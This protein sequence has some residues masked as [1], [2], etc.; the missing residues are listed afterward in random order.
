MRLSL[1]YCF[2]VHLRDKIEF[3]QPSLC[4]ED[5]NLDNRMLISEAFQQAKSWQK[6]LG[7]M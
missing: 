3:H 4:S 2:K 5:L 6:R 1:L 7:S